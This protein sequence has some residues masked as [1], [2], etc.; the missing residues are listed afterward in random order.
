MRRSHVSKARKKLF[1]GHVSKKQ[2]PYLSF[3]KFSNVE[4]YGKYWKCRS[5]LNK[6]K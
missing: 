3:L 5:L 2:K 4:M 1:D 6:S